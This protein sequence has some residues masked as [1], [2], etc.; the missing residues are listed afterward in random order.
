MCGRCGRRPFGL[1]SQEV[2]VDADFFDELGG[3]SL[4]AAT[5]VSMLRERG[6]AVNAAIRDLYANPTVRALAAHLDAAAVSRRAG[7]VATQEPPARY[8]TRSLALAGT[9][10]GGLIYLMLLVI[11]VPVAAVYANHNG[12]VSVPML[13]QLAVAIAAMYLGFRWLL[14]PFFVRLLAADIEPGR[15]RLW[16]WTYVRLWGVDLL[17]TL[18]PLP[19]L[20]GSPLLSVFLRL[21][22][23]RVGP[24]CDI[25]TADMTLPH[26][27]DIGAEASVGYGV[28]MRPW[29]VRDGHVVVA[30]VRVGDGAYVG[31]SA[32][33]EPGATVDT[34]AAVAAHS[35]VGDTQRIGERERWAGSPSVQAEHLDPT[36]EAMLAAPRLAGWNYRHWPAIGTAVALLEVLPLLMF[37]PGV[38]LVWWMLLTWNVTAGLVAAAVAGPLFVVTV[39][40]LICW[41][42]KLVLPQ[43][44]VGVYPTHSWLGI[45][46]W[47]ADKLLE[48][49][50]TFTN[51]LYATLYTVPWLRTLGARIGRDAEVSTAAHLDPDLLTLHDNSFV[52][53]MAS[54]GSA[55]FGNG[56][57]ALHRTEVGE[58]AFVGN[59]AV[60]PAGSTMGADS[61]VGVHTVPP[62]Q[63]VPERT[64]WLGSPAMYLPKRQDSGN[65]DVRMTYRPSRAR[66]YERLGIEF[67]R[68]TVPASLMAVAF[69]LYLLAISMVA[70]NAR[71][72]PVVALLAPVVAILASIGVVLTVVAVKWMIVGVYQSRVEPLWSRFVRRS[73]LVTGLYEAAAVPA[74]LN[75]LIG[76]PFLAPLLRMFGATIGHRGWI[77]TTFLT[78]FDL[79]DLGHDV[80]VGRGVSLQTHLF[81]DRVM[82]MSTVRVCDGATVGDRAIVLYDAV[83]GAGTTLDSLSL[84][85]KGE[86]LPPDSHWRGI[87]AQGGA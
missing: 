2:S 80:A 35:T 36:V 41:G 17:L 25:A 10:Q 56:R 72:F 87:P 53:D 28:E 76:T 70:D 30:P 39:C 31:A 46:K 32:V 55:A 54:V 49:S 67:F 60:V 13:I 24:G 79:V 26:L 1:P 4:L 64:S 38:A 14:V 12:R 33:L 11:S 34:R 57:M 52:A 29:T 61:L 71:S 3:H 6:V 20:S 73:E 51:S 59:A 78:E 16:G 37:V 19:V 69:Y 82:K 66:R 21:L 48:M 8:R 27:I 77:A 83:V 15:Y 75:L 23:A 85:M 9:A 68:I 47:I 44:P 58:R 81:E 40:V 74:L 84:A 43:T 63:G 18:S 42:R 86:Q 62:P 50:L 5:A 45:R 65:F 7:P 22:G